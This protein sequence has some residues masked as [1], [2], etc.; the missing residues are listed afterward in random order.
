MN[1][2]IVD[3]DQIQQTGAPIREDVPREQRSWAMIARPSCVATT[4]RIIGSAGACKITALDVIKADKVQLIM[5][6]QRLTGRIGEINPFLAESRE[7]AELDTG[8]TTLALTCNRSDC[9][10]ALQTIMRDNCNVVYASIRLLNI[11]NENMIGKVKR[12]VADSLEA[13]DECMIW[14]SW[15]Q[16]I[17]VQ[18]DSLPVEQQEAAEIIMTRWWN[19]MT[20]IYDRIATILLEGSVNADQTVD[21]ELGLKEWRSMANLIKGA[22]DY[23]EILLREKLVYGKYRLSEVSGMSWE[24]RRDLLN[25]L[26]ER[27]EL[28]LDSILD[29]KR[30]DLNIANTYEEWSTA[31]RA[32]FRL[33]ETKGMRLGCSSS[34]SS[35]DNNT[36]SSKSPVKQETRHYNSHSG[37][38]L[39]SALSSSNREPLS[40]QRNVPSTERFKHLNTRTEPRHVRFSLPV[41]PR[42]NSTGVPFKQKFDETPLAETEATTYDYQSSDTTK[43][44]LPISRDQCFKCKGM[45]VLWSGEKWRI[46]AKVVPGRA[47]QGRAC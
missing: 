47:G 13:P 43:K 5:Y 14:Y 33:A 1:A 38:Q 7:E 19:H 46:G 11:M 26:L 2:D 16:F 4:R 45:G 36:D 24:K 6:Y 20:Q 30:V 29:F 23:E 28:G 42:T 34:S 21:V 12:L 25:K 31:A 37:K 10:E 39:K 40:T 41:T 17:G 18:F 3:I 15:A 35:K 9:E 32:I 22:A 44:Q 27:K 8:C